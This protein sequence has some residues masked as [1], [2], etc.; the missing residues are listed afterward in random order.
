M[1]T[2]CCPHGSS[3]NELFLIVNAV[4]GLAAGAYLY[5][6]EPHGL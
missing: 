1:P 3:L 4:D 5:H 6:R 2:F